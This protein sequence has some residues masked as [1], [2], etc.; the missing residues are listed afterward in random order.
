MYI[1]IDPGDTIKTESYR[2]HET[3]T[4]TQKNLG[5]YEDIWQQLK[6]P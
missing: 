5:G 2:G 6:H 1:P 3:V 4:A